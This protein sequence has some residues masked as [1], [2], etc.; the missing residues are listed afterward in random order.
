MK[1]LKC[2]YCG[3]YCIHTN[4][5]GHYN[6][7]VRIINLV[8]HITFVVCVLILFISVRTYSLKSTPNDRSFFWETFHGNFL[9]YSQSSCQKFA[10]TKSPKK[11][12]VFYFDIWPRARTLALLLISLHTS[13]LTTVVP[14]GLVLIQMSV[15]HITWSISVKIYLVFALKNTWPYQLVHNGLDYFPIS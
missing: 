1:L 9:I 13:N 3:S 8:S 7:S 2:Q 10:E 4:L 12:F 15:D 11:Y 14:T 6:P 5:I